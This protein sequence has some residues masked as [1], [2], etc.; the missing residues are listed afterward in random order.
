[1]VEQEMETHREGG[2][3]PTEADRLDIYGIVEARLN[4]EMAAEAAAEAAKL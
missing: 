1:M 4:A 2:S 3:E